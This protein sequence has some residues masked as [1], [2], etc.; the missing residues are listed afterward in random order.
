[1]PSW[2]QDTVAVLTFQAEAVPVLAQGAHLLCC[3]EQ[4]RTGLPVALLFPSAPSCF[5]EMVGSVSRG[6]AP[7]CQNAS[8]TDRTESGIAPAPAPCVLREP[9]G[10]HSSSF[11]PLLG[12]GLTEENRLLATWAGPTHGSVQVSWLLHTVGTQQ[13]LRSALTTGSTHD[14]AWS[15]I[16][17]NP[18]F[19]EA[20]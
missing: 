3:R 5:R 2:G 16:G 12:P 13:G 14:S 1:M 9:C 6:P 4:G 17:L 20:H 15:L 18:L 10:S 19:L 7:S 8:P 11:L